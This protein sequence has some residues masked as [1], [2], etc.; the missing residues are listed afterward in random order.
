MKQKILIYLM[1]L[2][3]VLFGKSLLDYPLSKTEKD[4]YYT[5][6]ITESYTYLVTGE[7]QNLAIS[8]NYFNTIGINSSGKSVKVVPLGFLEFNYGSDILLLNSSLNDINNIGLANFMVTPF[9]RVLYNFN[10]KSTVPGLSFNIGPYVKFDYFISLFS[11]ITN[12]SNQSILGLNLG[13]DAKAKYEL[14]ETLRFNFGCSSFLVGFDMGRNG[15][16]KD[17]TENINI[18]NLGNYMDMDIT[19]S[20]ELDISRTE[21]I[22]LEYI[23]SVFSVFNSNN[24]IISGQN[25]IGISFIKKLVR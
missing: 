22:K 16:N 5:G 8:P 12:I 7:H 9:I 18:S 23:H 11:N 1:L 6:D 13:V 15:Y 2:S 3:S 24:T 20:G 17:L 4:L 10:F 14:L 19:L 21:T 25:S